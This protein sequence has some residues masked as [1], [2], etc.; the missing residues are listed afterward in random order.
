M[1]GLCK[2]TNSSGEEPPYNCWIALIDERKAKNKAHL[3]LSEIACA[4]VDTPFPI[5]YCTDPN[6]EFNNDKDW[7]PCVLKKIG[8]ELYEVL[9]ANKDPFFLKEEVEYHG[10]DGLSSLWGSAFKYPF[11]A[12]VSTYRKKVL[13]RNEGGNTKKFQEP[14]QLHLNDTKKFEEADTS[15]SSKQDMNRLRF[16]PSCNSK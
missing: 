16:A 6:N 9:D 1:T 8:R 13:P 15:A 2:P 12:F 10:D 11:L 7:E 4:R 3:Q 5:V 14:V